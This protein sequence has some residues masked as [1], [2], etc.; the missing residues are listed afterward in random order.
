MNLIQPYQNRW[1]E[2]F[3]KISMVIMSA[4]AP[5]DIYIEHVGSTAV[6]GLAG[7]PIIDIDVAFH[8]EVNFDEIN[9]R[10]IK[11]GYHHVGDQG[12]KGREVFKRDIKENQHPILDS[13]SHH[14]YVCPSHSEEL[15]RHLNF[16]DHLRENASSRMEYER[17][18][19]A[20]A[21]EAKQ[22]KKKYAQLKESMAK[23]FIES[24]LS[25]E[26]TE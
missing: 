2:D 18:K 9:K 16:R 12:I 20:L 13:I 23:E 11:I 10:L 25:I 5:L 14:L 19:L 15:K 4:L 3:I 22:D 17:L 6:R 8:G 21:D 24:L 26:D 1:A 7:K